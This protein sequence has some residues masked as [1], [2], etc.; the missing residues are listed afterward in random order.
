MPCLG[1]GPGSL[2]DILLS[3]YTSGSGLLPGNSPICLGQT[4][5]ETLGASKVQIFCLA[6][7]AQPPL[8]GTADRLGC[9]G[10]ENHGSHF[11]RLCSDFPGMDWAVILAWIKLPRCMQKPGGLQ[12]DRRQVRKQKRRGF[13]SFV[14]LVGKNETLRCSSSTT[15][16]RP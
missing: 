16:A 6:R 1:D 4:D 2:G 8:D 12:L 15:A 10:L 3:I 13:D 14:V 7:G 9:G 5:L 11:N